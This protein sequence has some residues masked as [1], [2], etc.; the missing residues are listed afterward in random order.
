MPKHE[1]QVS[2]LSTTTTDNG[3]GY[4][5]KI[6]KR[7]DKILS[8]CLVEVAEIPAPAFVGLKSLMFTDDVATRCSLLS[9]IDRD[10]SV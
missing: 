4:E 9:L 5:T 7:T 6:E 1:A 3:L 8:S 10:G 2:V